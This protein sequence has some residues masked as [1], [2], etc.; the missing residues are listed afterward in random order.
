MHSLRYALVA[1][2][3]LAT[4]LGI[5][6]SAALSST[7][8]SSTAHFTKATCP[9]KLG[10]GMVEGHTV[11]CGYL[12]V[13]EDYAK[14]TGRTIRLAVA[15]FKS[16]SAHPAPAPLIFLQGGPGGAI[17]A[18]LG[19]SIT[20]ENA[21]RIV[22]QQDL[23]LV[24]QRGNG[25]SDPFLGCNALRDSIVNV[26]DR[27]SSPSHDEETYLRAAQRCYQTFTKAGIDLNQ[28]TTLADA[29]DIAALGPALGYKQ[30]NV[31]GVSYGTRV[32]LTMMRSFPAHIRSVIIDAVLPTQ[33][34]MFTQVPVS[35]SRVF[36]V[37]FA[38]CAASRDCNKAYPHLDRTF[39]TL[40]DHLNAKPAHIEAK[41]PQTGKP[42]RVVLTGDRL[43]NVV[44]QMLYTTASIPYLPQLIDATA[45]GY[46]RDVD[47]HFFETLTDVVPYGSGISEGTYYSVECGEDAPF[48][49]QGQIAAEIDKMPT[50]LRS[51][52][53][54]SQF[55]SY[56]TCTH[57]WHVHTVPADQK[58][59]VRSGI[60]TLV[61]NGQYDP[62]TPP[63]LGEQAARTLSKASS[64]TYPGVGHGAYLSG[65]SCPHSMAVA[66]LADPD[67]RPDARCIE[68]MTAPKWVVTPIQK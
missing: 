28:Y 40:V 50:A 46:Y 57:A 8:H 4:A 58:H 7:T 10:K 64:Y 39:Y 26:L 59:A 65:E 12:V 36:G 1:L 49:T 16:P 9:F 29:E 32:A 11:H 63:D 38:G 20:S 14:P 34:N 67:K 47:Q 60:P 22:G 33:A 52:A 19:S 37:L 24:D 5:A 45:K 18:D 55:D 56:M 42:V 68:T 31:Y 17:V 15:D 23:I 43:V 35:M 41:D 27:A 30:V 25:L 6:P 61:L 66:F 3:L 44:F 13:P 48:T 51:T 62:I 21:H 54:A 2:F 53:R